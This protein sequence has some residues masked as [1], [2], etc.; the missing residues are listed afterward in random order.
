ME[1]AGYC[2]TCGCV[3]TSSAD[4]F[5]ATSPFYTETPGRIGEYEIIEEIARG[6]MGIV[7]RARQARLN[8]TVALKVLLGGIISHPAQVQRFNA[9]AQIVAALNHPNIISVYEIGEENGACYFSMPLVNGF[10]L[11]KIGRVQPEKAARYLQKIAAAVYHAHQRGVLHRDLKPNNVLIDEQ[12]EPRVVD[13]GIAKLTAE[14]HTITQTGDS[15]G[16]PSYMAPEQVHP[17]ASSIS[18]ATDIYALGGILYFLLTGKPP[19][20]GPSRDQTLWSVFYD[21]PMRPSELDPFLARDLETICLKCLA[22]EPADRYA[23][24]GELGED[25]RRY[26]AKEPIQARP[27]S[28]GRRAVLWGRRNPALAACA[29]AL[30]GALCYGVIAQQLALRQARKARA[31]AETLIEFMD[32]QLTDKL[33]PLGRLDLTADVVR[34]AEAYFSHQDEA[35]SGPDFLLRKASYF[36]RAGNLQRD[37]GKLTEA[38]RLAREGLA[39]LDRFQTKHERH[40]ESWTL[41]ARLELLVFRIDK[42]LG[43]KSET[44]DY[45]TRAL[46]D[47][48]RA[49]ELAP[50]DPRQI[51]ALSEI[52]IETGRFYRDEKQPDAAD[53]NLQEVSERLAKVSI[54]NPNDLEVRRLLAVTHYDRGL[55]EQAAHD[56]TSALQ[57]FKLFIKAL[58]EISPTASQDRDWQYELATAYGRAASAH[59]TLGSLESAEVLIEKWKA[60]AETLAASDP[61]NILWRAS[62]A[63]SL[64]WAGLVARDKAEVDPRVGELF[65]RALEEYRQLSRQVPYAIHHVSGNEEISASWVAERIQDM[66]ANL[67]RYYRASHQREEAEQLL[68][69]NVAHHFEVA[70]HSATSFA[71]H[72]NLAGAYNLLREFLENEQRRAEAASQCQLWLGQ[73]RSR[74]ADTPAPFLWHFAEAKVN[75]FLANLSTR[76][77]RYDQSVTHW[78]RSLEL[79]RGLE[80]LPE[81]DLGEDIS[82]AY[83][84]LISVQSKRANLPDFVSV[85]MEALNWA[86][87]APRKSGNIVAEVCL[88]IAEKAAVLDLHDQTVATLLLSCREQLVSDPNSL[89]LFD[90]KVKDRKLTLTH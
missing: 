16:T 45:A 34:E 81:I 64:A 83:R 70:L 48:R 37:L 41:R 18:V 1:P 85:S 50:E 36:W 35:N 67:V 71:A 4:L 55:A 23:T 61:N 88:G 46:A 21:E 74:F 12:D 31:D 22:K 40:A 57:E 19:F 66:T 5:N 53:A 11:S 32:K 58:E 80:N 56:N 13:F 69:A 25:L 6:G 76:T 24:A 39:T 33:R 3:T 15:L 44:K 26:L 14:T 42:A 27:I 90:E 82:F 72:K 10:D 38:D 51:A 62:L 54:L 68:R 60:T 84:S 30:I 29:A 2:L 86:T 73:L 47:Q 17:D 75:A 52:L 63:Q 20:A 77:E 49:V 87:S 28:L 7:Y 8:R 79:L 43:K 78:R 89:P 65:G 9:E 59:Y